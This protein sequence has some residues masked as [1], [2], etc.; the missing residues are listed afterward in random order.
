MPDIPGIPASLVSAPG[1]QMNAPPAQYMEQTLGVISA[2]VAQLKPGEQGKLVW[3]ANT[4]R[5]ATG[6]TKVGVNAVIVNRFDGEKVDFEVTAW[7]GAKWGE[8]VEAGVAGAI[9]WVP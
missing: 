8:P 9:S 7:L 5:T 3:V 1:V 2:A 4:Y 6:R